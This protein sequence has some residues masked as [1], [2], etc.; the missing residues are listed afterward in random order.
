MNDGVA[1]IKPLPWDALPDIDLYMDQVLRY[2]PRQGVEIDPTDTLTA[3]MV[4][5]YV[6]SGTMPGA[7]GKRYGREHLAYL[8]A[9]QT[10]KQ[11]LSVSDTKHLISYNVE[12]SDIQTFY[13][14]YLDILEQTLGEIDF[15]KVAD[16]NVNAN[17]IGRIA[18]KYAIISYA[19]K[20]VCERLLYIAGQERSET[21]NVTEEAEKPVKKEK[22]QKAAK[23][24]NDQTAE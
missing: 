18:L 5:N 20:L 13:G 7:H 6:K 24:K 22:K 11:V 23:A 17:D 15:A 4:S 21:K 2:M 12:A 3:S 16:E 8:T 9:I 14:E 10:L 1:E 19:N